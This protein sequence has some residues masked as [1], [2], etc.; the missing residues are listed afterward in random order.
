MQ[1]NFGWTL[2]S[3][4]GRSRAIPFSESMR[5]PPEKGPPV[6]PTNRIAAFIS[7]GEL[8]NSNP[9][10]NRRQVNIGFRGQ[11]VRIWIHL[12]EILLVGWK[13][14]GIEPL[15]NQL[16]KIG[17]SWKQS[18]MSPYRQQ[19]QI[20]CPFAWKSYELA[21]SQQESSFLSTNQKKSSFW[22]RKLTQWS[23]KEQ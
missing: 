17:F 15:R 20:R 22:K 10:S 1:P 14:I 5:P 13:P 8:L 3:S 2:L 9:W 12:S 6:C 11:W 21:D 7:I 19:V 16:M 4:R 18:C 23:E